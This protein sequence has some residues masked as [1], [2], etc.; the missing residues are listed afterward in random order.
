MYSMLILEKNTGGDSEILP[1]DQ[2]Y[3]DMYNEEINSI[4]KKILD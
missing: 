2:E 1:S 4:M 3:P